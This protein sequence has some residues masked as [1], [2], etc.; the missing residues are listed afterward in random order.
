M[1]P[2]HPVPGQPI[3]PAYAPDVLVGAAEILADEPC[4]VCRAMRIPETERNRLGV[5]GFAEVALAD[6]VPDVPDRTSV[7]RRGRT[8][9][10]DPPPCMYGL[11]ITTPRTSPRHP[12]R[13][14]PYVKLLS[15]GFVAFDLEGFTR[16]QDFNR[17]WA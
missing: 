5:V 6:P 14:E 16:Q 4:K 2:F 11:C 12:A 3:P 10:P 7:Q 9:Q 8:V 15:L 13:F 1:D 17:L